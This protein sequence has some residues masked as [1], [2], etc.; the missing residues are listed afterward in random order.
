VNAL[1]AAQDPLDA[2]LLGLERAAAQPSVPA[3][4]WIGVRPRFTQF[5]RSLLVTDA[6]RQDAATKYSG[7]ARSLSRAY[8]GDS[9][10]DHSFAVGSWAKGTATRP[11]RDVD[12]YFVLPS[13]VHERLQGYQWNRQSALLQ[14]MRGVLSDTFPKTELNGDR[15]VVVVRFDSMNVEVVPAFSLEGG[16]YWICDTKSGGSYQRTN[17]DAELSHIDRIDRENNGNL[18]AL[19]HMAKAWQDECHVPIKSFQLE[20]VAANFIEQSPW[21]R[22]DYFWYDWL[23]RDFFAFLRAHANRYLIVPGTLE[24]VPLGDAWLSRT[25]SA[26]VRARKACEL[27][28][29]NSVGLAG[30]EWQKIFGS[31]IPRWV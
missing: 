27:E 23:L 30:E 6:Q 9:S 26:L 12:M 19:I 21:R 5:H 8:Y 18:R 16:G 3:P 20:L 25:D 13:S 4:R 2:L 31:G 28:D 15:Q 11:P 1:S 10:L 29:W 22:Y 17:P 14:E 7:V 24:A